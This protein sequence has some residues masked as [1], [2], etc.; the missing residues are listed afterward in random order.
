MNLYKPRDQIHIDYYRNSVLQK[1]FIY[2]IS[3]LILKK[4]YEVF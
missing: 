2:L 3:L 4:K 1:R